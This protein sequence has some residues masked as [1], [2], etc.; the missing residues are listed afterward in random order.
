[1]KNSCEGIGDE[2]AILA[3]INGLERGSLLRH[4]LTR[5]KDA[6][7]LTLNSMIATASS[8]AAAD[9]DARGSLMATAIPNQ[10]KKNN[11]RKN[12]AEDQ[13][14]GSDMV[15]MTFQQRGQGGN[16]GRGRGGGGGRGQQ[17]SDEVT[18]AAPRPPTTYEEYRDMPCLAHL[19]ANGKSTHT[20]RHCKFVNDLKTDPEAGYKRARRKR[21]R[22]KGGK[23]EDKESKETSDMDEDE[24]KSEPKG[25]VAA[26]SKNPY[27]K[28][29]NGCFHTFLGTPSAKAKKSALR[30]LNATVPPVPQYVKWSKNI[31]HG[32]GRITRKSFHMDTMPW[33]S[34]H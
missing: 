10:S 1:M 26:K 25:D 2:T 7:I 22:G 15:A 30:S 34:I 9:D 27:E 5:E 32:I 11:K 23:S 14:E 12:P 21:P 16:R 8:Y 29:S 13:K 4:T 19:D 3:Y 17:R 6:G 24:A 28:K 20:N 31:S 18:R 33:S